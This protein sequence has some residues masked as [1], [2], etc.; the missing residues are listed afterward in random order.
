M[1]VLGRQYLE[2]KDDFESF[3]ESRQQNTSPG[4]QPPQQQAQSQSEPQT[5]AEPDPWKAPDYDSKW[6]QVCEYDPS[7]GQYVVAEKYASLVAPS[8]ADKLTQYKSW[9]ANNARRIAREFP[10]LVQQHIAKALEEFKTGLPDHVQQV[11][12]QRESK[13]TADSFFDDNKKELFE[14][15]ATG[16]V[17]LD[18]AGDAVLTKKGQAFREH[19]MKLRNGGMTDEGA[20]FEAA[21]EVASYKVPAQHGGSEG[22]GQVP[23]T[24]APSTTGPTP[25]QPA[26]PQ[27]TPT[28]QPSPTQRNEAQKT[29]FLQRAISQEE[30]SPNRDATVATAAQQEPEGQNPELDFGRMLEADMAS[31]GLLPQTG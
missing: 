11:L 12:S 25:T 17:K 16:E 10:D 19:A 15:D 18:A 5:L 27:P 26:P 20:I 14:L 23:Q 13:Q 1:A 24:P 3:L 2:H 29:S 31:A 7:I 22:N 4:R 21:M 9:E 8:V 28:P 6:E 30:H